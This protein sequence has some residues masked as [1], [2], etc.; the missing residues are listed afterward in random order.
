MAEC[1]ACRKPNPE[2]AK[3]CQF[4]GTSQS[5]PS[6]VD[7]ASCPACNHANP[8]RRKF[9][10]ACGHPLKTAADEA[11]VPTSNTLVVP[12]DTGEPVPVSCPACEATNRPGRKFCQA[13]GVSLLRAHTPS[14]ESGAATE[15]QSAG[16]DTVATSGADVHNADR[17]VGQTEQSTQPTQAKAN[18]ELPSATVPVNQV[19]AMTPMATPVPAAMT[20]AQEDPFSGCPQAPSDNLPPTISTVSPLPSMPYSEDPVPT[21]IATPAEVGG[22]QSKAAQSAPEP[23]TSANPPETTAVVEKA[24]SAAEEQEVQASGAGPEVSS[25][26][27]PAAEDRDRLPSTLIE[28]SQPVPT[29]MD[30]RMEEEHPASVEPASTDPSPASP[31]SPPYRKAPADEPAT[32]EVTPTHPD[33]TTDGPAPT[34]PRRP[35]DEQLAPGISGLTVPKAPSDTAKSQRRVSGIQKWMYALVGLV[36][37]VAVVVGGVWLSQKPQQ[38]GQVAKTAASGPVADTPQTLAPGTRIVETK[39]VPAESSPQPAPP[40]SVPDDPPAASTPAEPE[41]APTTKAVTPPAAAAAPTSPAAESQAEPAK[42]ARNSENRPAEARKPSSKA[43]SSVEALRRKKEE[44]LRQLRQ[45]Q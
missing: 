13:C 23:A 8:A 41:T 3:F 11:A 39:D 5:S 19:P 6:S 20:L 21:K 43:D 10:A 27:M 1:I 24:I 35:E 7:C 45:S 28:H 29:F 16:L 22:G 37:T 17:S 25:T 31:G 9:C 18:P 44:L 40:P 4:C 30:G 33:P 38:T 32:A 12:A 36:G 2:H 34:E 26:A 15:P 14:G 42:P